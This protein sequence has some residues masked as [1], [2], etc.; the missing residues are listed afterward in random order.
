[1]SLLQ[2]PEPLRDE[3]LRI[4]RDK[5]LEGQLAPGEDINESELA[6]ELG[7]SRTTLWRK[8]KKHCIARDEFHCRE[9]GAES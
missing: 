3:V 6:E 8:M 9:N 1:M 7:I 4:L 5:V 2:R